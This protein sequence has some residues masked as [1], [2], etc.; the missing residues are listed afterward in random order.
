[1]NKPMTPEQRIAFVQRLRN[2]AHLLHGAV[3]AAALV[4][5]LDQ[6]ILNLQDPENAAQTKYAEMVK[7]ARAGDISMQAEV[8]QIRAVRISNWLAAK[9]NALTF[10][11]EQALAPNEV[12]YVI[13][14][15]GREILV[16]TIGQDGQP[17]KTQIARDQTEQQFQIRLLSTEE[18]EYPLI[19]V[20]RGN[21]ADET[22]QL[23]DLTRELNTQIDK[24]AWPLVSGNVGA[25]GAIGAFVTTGA[26]ANRTYVP[27]SSINTNNLPTT[28]LLVSSSS[29][30]GTFF[31]KDCMDAILD[32]KMAWGQTWDGLTSTRIVVYIPSKD[33]AGWTRSITMT[34]QPNSV[35]EQV[36]QDGVVHHYAGHDWVFVADPTLDPNAG[37][38]YVRLG[39][40]LGTYFTKPNLDLVRDIMTPRQEMQNKG[41]MWARKAYCF[42]APAQNRPNVVAI[43]YKNA[44]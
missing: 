32:Y 21:V 33:A 12:P 22:K 43:R 25:G 10:F 8:A 19:D 15:T 5:T 17:R 38:A 35:A 40:A 18:V 20:I 13:N 36:L 34:T 14:E 16:C 31:N 41:S 37:L 44:A 30:N 4:G 6:M 39:N 9:S 26:R 27:H 42:V 29:G 24:I 11:D 23:V 2:R 3:T 28:N 7:L 1:M